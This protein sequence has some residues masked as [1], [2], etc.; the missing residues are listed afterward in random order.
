MIPTK[1]LLRNDSGSVELFVCLVVVGDSGYGIWGMME[2]DEFL[3]SRTVGEIWGFIDLDDK[4]G[5]TGKYVRFLRIQCPNKAS[6][7][8]WL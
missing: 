4:R 7:W 5:A 6:S 8:P 2:T 3:P 1:R